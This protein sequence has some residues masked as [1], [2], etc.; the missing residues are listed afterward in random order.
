MGRL[1]SP[2]RSFWNEGVERQRRDSKG[3]AMGLVDSAALRLAWIGSPRRALLTSTPSGLF[4][5]WR[6]AMASSLPAELISL[7]FFAS[8]AEGMMDFLCACQLVSPSE[9][10]LPSKAADSVLSAW[11]AWDPE[12]LKRFLKSHFERDWGSQSA[13]EAPR[14]QELPD[15]SDSTEAALAACWVGACRLDGLDPAHTVIP[16]LFLLDF[17]LKMP[18]GFAY[19]NGPDGLPR[20]ADLDESGELSDAWASHPGLTAEGLRALGWIPEARPQSHK[21]VSSAPSGSQASSASSRSEAMGLMD[22]A[23]LGAAAAKGARGAMDWL[24]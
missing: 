8:A 22:A 3:A 4:N 16:R 21:G 13:S 2:E 15:P 10:A 6:S 17:T 1:S 23:S 12:G 24:G 19:M 9:C 20:H 5:A 18:G 11:E 14:A 7:S